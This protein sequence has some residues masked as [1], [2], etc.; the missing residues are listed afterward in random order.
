MRLQLVDQLYSLASSPLDLLNFSIM[1][2]AKFEW[3]FAFLCIVVPAVATAFP[4]G[5]LKIVRLEVA[6]VGNL[7]EVAVPVMNLTYRRDDSYQATELGAL[8]KP[9]GDLNVQ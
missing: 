1:W 3:L 2:N 9:D 6:Q 4:P 8:F 5:S 7:P